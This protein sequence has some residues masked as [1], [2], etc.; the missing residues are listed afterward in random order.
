M[1]ELTVEEPIA[2][3]KP[4]KEDIAKSFINQMKT[5]KDGQPDMK[6]E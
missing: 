3:E 2:A 6:E 5:K 4:E 1:E